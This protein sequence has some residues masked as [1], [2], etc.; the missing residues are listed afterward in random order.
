MSFT[1]HRCWLELGKGFVAVGIAAC[2]STS[3]PAPSCDERTLPA[4]EQGAADD[5]NATIE[6]FWSA[7]NSGFADGADFAADDWSQ[8]DSEGAVVSGRE[9]T[10]AAARAAS[11]SGTMVSVEDVAIDFVTRD[12]AVAIVSSKVDPQSRGADLRTSFVVVER[13]RV[14]SVLQTHNTSITDEA[15]AGCDESAAAAFEQADVDEPAPEA[16]REASVLETVRAF[17]KAFNA[18]F[19][20]D[21]AFATQDWNHIR[22]TGAWSRGRDQVLADMRADHAIVEKW[23]DRVE[24]VSVRFATDSVAVATATSV[25][26]TADGVEGPLRRTFVVVERNDAWLVQ[27]SHNTI[28][29]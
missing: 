10:V 19:V 13:D 6:S 15:T 14:W 9:A 18:G 22:P 8:V 28:I 5:V 11:V 27:L 29:R 1:L 23:V 12:V 17:S 7:Y 26:T 25:V 20:G 4:S 21:G 16:E 2:S 3:A 24:D